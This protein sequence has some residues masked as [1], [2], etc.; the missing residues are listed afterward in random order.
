MGSVWAFSILSSILAHPSR[1]RVYFRKLI[2]Q[3]YHGAL[4]MAGHMS[5]AQT[6]IHDK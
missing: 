4:T 6:R 5:G 2:G 3:G 1:I